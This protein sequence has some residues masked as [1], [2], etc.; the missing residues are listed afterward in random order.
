M[1]NVVLAMFMSLDGYIEGPGRRMTPPPY[2]PDLQRHWISRNMERA[3]TMMYGRVAYEGMA[4]F[5]TSPQAPAEQ[6]AE[7]AAMD[8]LVFSRSL[9]HADWGRVTI[10]RDDIPGEIVRRKTEPGKD[11]L[12]LGGGDIARNFLALGLVDELCL[13]LSPVLLGGGTRLFEGE[14]DKLPLQLAEALPLDNGA[15]RLTYLKR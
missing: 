11:M 2:S 3:G 13:L 15:V 7:L 4:K 1:R 8:K 5:W 14:H 12:L 6:A 10:I 9:E